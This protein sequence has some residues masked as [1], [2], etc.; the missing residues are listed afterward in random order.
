MPSLNS[1]NWRAHSCRLCNSG[2]SKNISIGGQGPHFFPLRRLLCDPLRPWMLRFIMRYKTMRKHII[3][4]QRSYLGNV[5]SILLI[6][7]PPCYNKCVLINIHFPSYRRISSTLAIRC[8]SY[9]AESKKKKI[10]ISH[11]LC[12]I[13]SYRHRC[14]IEEKWRTEVFAVSLTAY[15]QV[16]GRRSHT[17]HREW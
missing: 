13:L 4:M 10:R 2:G 15:C 8:M 9:L 11:N 5:Y 16:F 14:N 17:L 12:S 3:Y 7:F 1:A 6:L